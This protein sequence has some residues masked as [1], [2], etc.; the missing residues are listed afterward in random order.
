ARAARPGAGRV[1]VINLCATPGEGPLL[2]L[3]HGAGAPM[4]SPV[5]EHLAQAVSE[6]GMDV[7][8]FEFPFMAERRRG[9][10]RRPPDRQPVLLASWREQLARARA[11]YPGR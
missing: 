7:W 6:A 8:R 5:M 3:A 4:D 10:K 1:A 2:L 11:E 9:G